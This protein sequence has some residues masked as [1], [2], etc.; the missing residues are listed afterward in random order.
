MGSARNL[1]LP[2]RTRLRFANELIDSRTEADSTGRCVDRSK[3]VDLILKIDTGSHMSKIH[4][5]YNWFIIYNWCIGQFC[6]K[7]ASPITFQQARDRDQ[8]ILYQV[9]L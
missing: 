1:R 8:G 4:Q 7:L 6:G 5:V 9:F 3:F 2:G